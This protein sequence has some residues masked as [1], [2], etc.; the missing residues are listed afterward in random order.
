MRCAKCHKNEATI[1]FTPV[2]DGKPQKTVPFCKDCASANTG[3]HFMESKKPEALPVKGKRCDFCGRR[4]RFGHIDKVSGKA[5]YTCTD[6]ATELRDIMLDLGVAE[7]P[8]LMER[9]KGTVTFIS[10][11]TPAVRTWLQA[12]GRR[13]IEILSE[14]RRQHGRDKGS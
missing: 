6:C 7:K 1:H 11:D 8:H 10:R 5:G 14:M 13:A 9:I 4:A 2:A 3:F 12:A